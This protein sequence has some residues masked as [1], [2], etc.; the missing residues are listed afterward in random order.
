MEALREYGDADPVGGM[1]TILVAL[2]DAGAPVERLRDLVKLGQHRLRRREERG[3]QIRTQQAYFIGIL[4]RLARQA[5]ER[6]WD[7][8]AM[9]AEDQAE[10]ANIL[11]Q[12]AMKHLGQGRHYIMPEAEPAGEAEAEQAAPEET[13][14]A[15]S[16]TSS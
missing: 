13:R 4:Q 9:E 3:G 10:H 5:K 15:P 14:A 12:R 6:G 11:R 1:R 8:T 2:V 7:V 16:Y